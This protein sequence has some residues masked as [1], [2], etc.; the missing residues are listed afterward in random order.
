MFLGIDCLI[1]PRGVPFISE[2]NIGLPGGI[3]EYGLIEKYIYKR[4]SNIFELIEEIS[5]QKHGKS[6]ASYI[7]KSP[8]FSLHQKFKIW[9]DREGNLPDLLAPIFRLEDKWNQYLLLKKNFRMPYTEIFSGNF[10]QLLKL[11]KKYGKIALKRRCGRWS[12]GFKVFDENFSKEDF[13]EI[14][15]DDYICQQY[16]ESKIDNYIFSVRIN[17]FAGKFLC[18]TGDLT[19]SYKS[20]W[21]YIVAIE[22]GKNQKIEKANFDIL[23]ILEPAWESK[24]WCKGEIPEHM[25]LNLTH[26][27]LA[28]TK[29]FLK[30]ETISEMKEMAIGIANLYEKIDLSQLPPAFFEK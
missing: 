10:N 28:L 24:I 29:V 5:L 20:V 1:D 9:M 23:D 12:K 11:S 8:Y 13:N 7:Q 22:E 4:D 27:K 3:F 15:E 26:D 2:V 16:I 17:T 21:R 6:F 14:K 19:P 18:L 30:K 25:K